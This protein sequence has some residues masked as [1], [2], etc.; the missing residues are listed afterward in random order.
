MGLFPHEV[1]YAGFVLLYAFSDGVEKRTAFYEGLYFG[2][3]VAFL[4][5]MLFRS[6]EQWNHA[7]NKDMYFLLLPVWLAFFHFFGNSTL[8][9]VPTPSLFHWMYNA[10]TSISPTAD[11]GHGL[12]MPFVVMMLFWWKRKELLTRPLSTWWPGLVLV[13][14]AAVLHLAGF[15]VQQPRVSIVALFVGIYGLMGLAWGLSFLKASFFPFFLFAFMVPLGSLTEPITFP[16]RLMVSK[17]VAFIC[18]NL[19]AI[20]VVSEGT[21]LVRL[22]SRYQYEVAAACSGIRSLVA[23]TAIAIIY[24]FMVFKTWKLRLL[25]IGSAIP[26]AVIGNTFRMM[27]IVLAA[28]IWGQAAGVKAHDSTFWSMLPYVPAIFGLMF[29]GRWLEKIQDRQTV[30]V[31]DGEAKP[32]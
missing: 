28:E 25:L 10:Y 9:Y 8:G 30:V 15:L 2:L 20:D 17:L 27:V 26:L 1:V 6:A 18:Q 24:A 12:L 13:G 22:P 16:L 11:D 19:L 31:A 4:P 3:V 5:I 23:V 21:S 7:R 14:L 29:L 32:A